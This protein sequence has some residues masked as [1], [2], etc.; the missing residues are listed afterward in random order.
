[1]YTAVCTL[2][3]HFTN[4]EW[5]YVC[6]VLTLGCDDSVIIDALR[7][8]LSMLDEVRVA[9]VCDIVCLLCF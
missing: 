7:E 9:V 3:K 1:M 4:N 8:V 5:M 6:S 2:C